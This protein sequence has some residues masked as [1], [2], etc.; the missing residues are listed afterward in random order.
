MALN[1][2]FTQEECKRMTDAI[3]KAESCS[4]AEVR[5]HFDSKCKGDPYKRA[6]SLFSS[7]KMHK[8]ELRNGVLIYIAMDDK[9]MAIVGDKGINAVVGDNFWEDTIG[10]MRAN[11]RDGDIVGGVSSALESVGYK[12]KEFFPYMEDDKNELSDEISFGE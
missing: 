9:K 6:I 10:G 8:T 5:V 2:Y 11:F 7:L 1:R 4:S 12:L 3:A